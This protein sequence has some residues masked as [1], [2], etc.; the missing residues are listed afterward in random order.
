MDAFVVEAVGTHLM[1]FD[2]TAMPV[3]QDARTRGLGEI[4]IDKINIVGDIEAPKQMI[5]Q[6][7]SKLIPKNVRKEY[8]WD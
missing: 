8:G 3:L 5:I 2:P 6:A 7:F 4:N 1:G